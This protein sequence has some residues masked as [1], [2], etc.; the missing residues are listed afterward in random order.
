MFLK[1][2]DHNFGDD[3]PQISSAERGRRQ[4]EMFGDIKNLI[5]DRLEKAHQESHKRYDLCHRFYGKALQV[6]QMVYR[7]HMKQSSAL[8]EYNA[9]FG[10]QYL[11]AKVVRKIGSSSYEIEDLDGKSLGVWPAVHLKPA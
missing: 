3:D 4:A 10:P 11:P 8:E 7:R 5:Q 9:K 2:S 1:G 6:G